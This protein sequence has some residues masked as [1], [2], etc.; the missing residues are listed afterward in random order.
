MKPQL[1]LS[2]SNP[3]L[4]SAPCVLEWYEYL[5]KDCAGSG[6]GLQASM[7][8]AKA[9]NMRAATISETDYVYDES[10]WKEINRRTGDG[11]TV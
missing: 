3:R 4:I 1:C 9:K 5:E 7:W 8:A 10:L 6:S 2:E 11:E